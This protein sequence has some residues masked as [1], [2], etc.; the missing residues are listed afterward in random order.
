MW[1]SFGPINLEVTVPPG[2]AFRASAPCEKTA[3]DKADVYRSTLKDKTGELFLA[4]DSAAWKK[5][6]EPPPAKTK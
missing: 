6:S 1:D 3:G 4:V 2:V 5:P